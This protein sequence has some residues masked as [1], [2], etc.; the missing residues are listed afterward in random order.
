MTTQV[1][2]KKDG[3]YAVAG[4][5]HVKIAGTYVG[6]DSL[7][8]K[9]NGAYSTGST[10]PSN[11]TPPVIAGTGDLGSTLTATPGVW[12]GNPAPTV[13]GH[14][15]ADSDEIKGATGLTFDVTTREMG[16]SITYRETGVNPVGGVT[17][18]SNA[19]QA[20]AAAA[21]TLYGVQIDDYQDFSRAYWDTSFGDIYDGLYHKM[22][23][24][25]KLRTPNPNG[26]AVF[27]D[28]DELRANTTTSNIMW[29][30]KVGTLGKI[31]LRENNVGT[32]VEM[33]VGQMADAIDGR[34]SFVVKPEGDNL[35]IVG[36]LD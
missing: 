25:L 20:E 15:F 30:D 3:A 8:M 12:A 32:D 29:W 27:A 31:I 35:I 6:T 17:V 14:W 1:T 2:V 5:V 19:I 4:A 21:G 11:T 23:F 7:R 36:P 24:F 16:K 34:M 9:V 33:T 22:E 26:D 13:M 28:T 10:L 18:A